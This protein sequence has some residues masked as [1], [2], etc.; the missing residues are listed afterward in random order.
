MIHRRAVTAR[1]A[2][3][4]SQRRR[5]CIRPEPP[6]CRLQR[7]QWPA[8]RHRPPRWI[9]LRSVRRCQPPH[10]SSSKA[11]PARIGRLNLTFPNSHTCPHRAAVQ[12]NKVYLTPPASVRLTRFGGASDRRLSFEKPMLQLQPVF[13]LDGHAPQ[14]GNSLGQCG[15]L[16]DA[17]YVANFYFKGHSSGPQESDRG[18][19]APEKH[20]A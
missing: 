12:S 18:Q 5:A 8:R 19:A 1:H 9:A 2:T 14:W 3:A 10:D 15:S 4:R 11:K 6:N 20:Q 17:S 7:H 13:R 16:S